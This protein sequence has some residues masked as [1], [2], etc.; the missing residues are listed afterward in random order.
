MH[1]RILRWLAVV[2]LLGGWGWLISNPQPSIAQ[3]RTPTP[4]ATPAQTDGNPSGSG[5]GH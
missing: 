2:M 5:G 4:T 1:K 3:D